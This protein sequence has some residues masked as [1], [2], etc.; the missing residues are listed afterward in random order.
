MLEPT[1]TDNNIMNDK[2]IRMRGVPTACIKYYDEPE[3]ITVLYM[4][5]KNMKVKQ[6][7]LI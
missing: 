7:H 1:N 3:Q 4:F 2:H 6:L 5:K